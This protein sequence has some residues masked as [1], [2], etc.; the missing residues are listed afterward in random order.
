MEQWTTLEQWLVVSLFADEV[1]ATSGKCTM[2]VSC[3]TNFPLPTKGMHIEWAKV[4]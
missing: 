3:H 1:H 2:H 4:L